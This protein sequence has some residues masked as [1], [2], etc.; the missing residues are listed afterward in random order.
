MKQLKLKEKN[1]AVSELDPSLDELRAM[2]R[3]RRETNKRI[4]EL[5]ISLLRMCERDI[6]PA[7]RIL[8]GWAEEK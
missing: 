7:I 6:E 3:A 8:R 4:E 5:K 1:N 2:R